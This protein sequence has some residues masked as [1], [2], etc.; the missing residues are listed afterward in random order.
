MYN[1]KQNLK[2]SCQ[3]CGKIIYLI[4]TNQYI[5][6]IVRKHQSILLF[7]SALKV[8]QTYAKIHAFFA[9]VNGT[10]YVKLRMRNFLL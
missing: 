5:Y 1:I 6:F 3:T 4:L 2:H 9:I 7:L 10:I 8:L